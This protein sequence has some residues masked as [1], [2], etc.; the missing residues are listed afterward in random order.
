LEEGVGVGDGVGEDWRLRKARSARD[1]PRD[2][3]VGEEGRLGRTTRA[4]RH[5]RNNR[6][7]DWHDHRHDN[8]LVSVCC[9]LRQEIVNS[10]LGEQDIIDEDGKDLLAPVGREVCQ[11]LHGRVQHRSQGARQ[12]GLVWNKGLGR[13]TLHAFVDGRRYANG[14]FFTRGATER[15]FTIVR[16]DGRRHANGR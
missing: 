3:G 11:R 1:D 10:V 2:D 9:H 7:D 14:R 12:G 8:R 13:R 6:R 15:T 5:W 16:G 4:A